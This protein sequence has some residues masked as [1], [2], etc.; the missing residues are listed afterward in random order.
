MATDS[1]K[2][3][4]VLDLRREG[5]VDTA[6]LS[7][8]EITPRE[9]FVLP[10]FIDQAYDDTALPIG[11]GQTISQPF[12]VAYMLQ[13][14]NL[15]KRDKILEIG[16]GS[17]YLTAVLA[18]LCRRVYSLERERDLLLQAQ[19]ILED[20]RIYNCTLKM[21]D[22]WKGWPEQGPF[23]AIVV[24]AAAP[25]PPQALL[26]Q[27]VD[28]GRLVI[29]IGKAADSQFLMLYEKSGTQ[30]KESKLIPVRFVPLTTIEDIRH[31]VSSAE[32][33]EW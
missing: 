29:P 16:T 7:A 17:G 11:C 27:L 2:I 9:K 3:R 13:N 6:V 20:L 19:K 30:I 31:R 22:G 32:H 24:S 5:I 33:E 12:V 1:R 21:G 10:N 23:H 26:D 25:T 28:G 8:I 15:K 18:K 14:L 4:L